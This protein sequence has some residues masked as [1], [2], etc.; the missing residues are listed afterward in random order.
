MRE[1]F[2]DFNSLD[3]DPD[4]GRYI[5]LGTAERN[6]ELRGLVDGERVLLKE[7]N[8]LQAEGRVVSRVV[9]GEQWWLG[10]LT[11]D[12]QVIYQERASTADSS[13]LPTP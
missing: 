2:A 9:R 8:E 3:L 5:P 12:I 7:P 10:V 1:L 13:P 4:L 11:G 6:E